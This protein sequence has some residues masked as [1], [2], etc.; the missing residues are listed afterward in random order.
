MPFPGKL[1]HAK[2]LPVRVPVGLNPEKVPH[3]LTPHP[4]HVR[5]YAGRV[6]LY[7]NILANENQTPCIKPSCKDTAYIIGIRIQYCLYWIVLPGA[8]KGDWAH[9]RH[10][11]RMNFL[12]QNVEE[13]LGNASYF[14]SYRGKPNLS[15]IYQL[16]VIAPYVLLPVKIKA[17]LFGSWY[18]GNC[19]PA[20]IVNS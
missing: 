14:L 2:H 3:F 12:P 6:K 15:E 1:E 4:F 11:T 8:V 9:D 20:I 16:P 7:R 5:I 18:H 19:F 17:R 13:L 10:I